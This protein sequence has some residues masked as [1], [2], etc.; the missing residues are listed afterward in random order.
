M[1]TLDT[2]I[3]IGN[4]TV[5]NR[6]TFAP[7][8]KF[9][10]TD[11]SGLVTDKL[12]EH[13]K[14]RA[15]GGAGLICV[16][17]TAV[18]PGGRFGK[19]HMG[20]WSDEQIEGH[21]RITKACHDANAVVIIQLNHAGYV[22][23]GDCGPHVGPSEIEID[24]YAGK[25]TT[26]A[27]T[28]DEVHEYQ[29]AYVDAAVRAQKAGYDGIQL[30]G[31]HGYL[32]NQFVSPTNNFRTD[33]YGGN[34][35]NR[36]R[37]ASE[38]ISSIR[39]LCGPDFLISVRT[40]GF[41]KTVEDA[42][43]VAEE[44]VNAG[45]DYLQVSAG[46][47]SFDE[48]DD[49]KDPQIDKFPSLGCRFKDHFKGRVPVSNVGGILTPERAKYFIE[50]EY[51]DTVDLARAILADPDFPNAA[52]TGGNYTKCFQCKACQYGPFTNHVCPAEMVRKKAEV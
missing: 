18:L 27:L 23:N 2:P 19:N 12:V 48:I 47:T 7:T 39:D 15:L 25:Y 41:D 24:S 51:V 6:I 43:E 26:H 49:F 17:A 29:K 5:K 37:F 20:L 38:I 4:F 10:F 28:L 36:A 22:C 13:Y 8:V 46:M 31:C 30:H 9:D 35:K 34:A 11:D 21:K 40:T 3:K 32:I 1:V 50:N 44:Y 45:C 42:I 33:E 14:E 52:I 16:E